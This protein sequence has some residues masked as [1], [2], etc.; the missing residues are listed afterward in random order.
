MAKNS[1]IH[2]LKKH[3]YKTGNTIYF[4]ILPDCHYKLDAALSLG[5]KSLC[6]I[7]N[8]EFTMTEATLKLQ[9]PHCMDCGK[10]KV[11]DADGNTRYVKKVVNKVLTDIGVS[12]ATDLRSRLA[13]VTQ[14]PLDDDI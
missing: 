7:C 4:C 14:I 12:H 9:R 8:A 3:R 1:H 13:S 11:Q 6:N 2:K 5:K 10:V